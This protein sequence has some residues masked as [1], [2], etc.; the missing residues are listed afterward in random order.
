MRRSFAKLIFGGIALIAPL[1][2]ANSAHAGICGWLADGEVS[3]ELDVT[4]G[5]ETKCTP[6]HFEAQCGFQCEGSCNVDVDVDCQASCEDNCMVDCKPGHIDCQGQCET[7]C[8]G[9]CDTYCESHPNETDCVTTC[10][11]NCTTSC[12][13]HCDVKPA[14]CE[15]S[16]KAS[17]QGSCSA[18]V[19]ASCQ[20][21][22]VGNCNAELVGG[23]KTDCQAPEGALFC[24]GQYVTVDNLDDCSGFVDIE[25]ECHGN[26]CTVTATAGGCNTAGASDAPIDFAALGAM[27]VGCGLI[28]SR[29]RKSA[30]K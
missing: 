27:A 10:R 9:E 7:D 8:R 12:S 3:C 11:G 13:G 17:C 14:T 20:A 29:R 24:D 25:G 18:H 19:D 15:A 30:K 22:C 28:V 16:C 23:C 21:K 1:F 5:C 6:L 4:G 26:T 2:V